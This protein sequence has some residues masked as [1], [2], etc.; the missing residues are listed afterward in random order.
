VLWSERRLKYNHVAGLPGREP[1]LRRGDDL[2]THPKPS[3]RR[4]HALPEHQIVFDQR[5]AAGHA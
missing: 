4:A 1:S 5:E 2:E 3:R